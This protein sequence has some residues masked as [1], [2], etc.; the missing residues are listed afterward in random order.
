METPRASVL[1]AAYN[2]ED[3]LPATVASV[4]SQTVEHVELIVVD[5]GS[6]VPV[7][8]VLAGVDDPRLRIVVHERNRGL[9]AAR[10]T[11]LAHARAP[12]VSQLDSD[13]R[14]EP[15]YLEAVLPLFERQD[16]GL[17]YTD[18]WVE[19]A[20]ART[21]YIGEGGGEHPVQGVRGLLPSCPIPNPTVTMR[22]GAVLDVRGYTS[23][24]WSTQD[25][26][27]YL[28]LAHAG[29]RFG[30]VDRPLATYVQGEGPERMTV[31][32][33]RIQRDFMRMWAL[34]MLEHP[35]TIPAHASVLPMALRGLRRRL[36][37]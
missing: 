14:W 5:D 11:A 1:T 19:S 35:S 25:W 10:N 18:A 20:G 36:S 15:G 30:Y 37:A 7:R 29:W 34:F 31:D 26:H 2:R 6:S 12:L 22:R 27:L 23:R 13:D 17:V 9:S 32:Q 4:L 3:T 24:L 8:E 33:R 28:E 16:I 21:R